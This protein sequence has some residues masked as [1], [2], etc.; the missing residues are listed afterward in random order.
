M[1]PMGALKELKAK[2]FA[3]PG[4]NTMRSWRLKIVHCSGLD[5]PEIGE[6]RLPCVEPAPGE[7]PQGLRT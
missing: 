2:G 6:R 3:T 5:L 1:S 7:Y 4:G